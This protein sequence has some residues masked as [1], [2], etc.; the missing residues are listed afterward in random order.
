MKVEGFPS[1]IIFGEDTVTAARLL[2]AGY[3][4]AYLEEA[5]A[6]HSHTYT[7]I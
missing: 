6:D 4:I 1:N 5:C 3:K 7:K 2:S